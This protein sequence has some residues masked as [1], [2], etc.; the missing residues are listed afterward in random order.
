MAIRGP[1]AS[2]FFPLTFVFS[3]G[4]LCVRFFL[5]R[6]VY[7]VNP[8]QL[9]ALAPAPASFRFVPGS[10]RSLPSSVFPN[11]MLSTG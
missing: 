8:N 1:E 5:D 7:K 11:P 10:A 2:S 3:V 9:P 6:F 4:F